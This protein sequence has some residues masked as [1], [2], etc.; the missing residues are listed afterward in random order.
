MQ[1]NRILITGGAGFVGSSLAAAFMKQYPNC[2]VT[3]FD[4]LMRRGSE[5]N[6]EYLKEHGVRFVHG[7]VRCCTDFDALEP[8]DLLIDCSAEPSVS[9][10]LDQG[11]RGLVDINFNGTVN[12]L[13]SARTHDAAVLFVST[14]RVYPIETLRKVY[15][16]EG[17][18]RLIVDEKQDMLGVTER[19]ISER[20][21]IEGPRS[22]Y[23]T[24]K[25]ASEYLLQEY[26]YNFGMRGLINRCGILAGPRQMGRI[27]QGVITFWLANHIFERPLKYMGFGGTGKQV[28]DLL[29]VDDLFDLLVRQ[30]ADADA[31]TG[32]VFNV[33]GGLEHSVSLLELTEL[34]RAITGKEV[35]ITAQPDT[36]SVDIPVYLSDCEKAKAAF[37]WE[38]SRGVEPT[39]EEIARWIEGDLS[40][41]QQILG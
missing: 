41:L 31:W 13:E 4:N 18:T 10:G 8:F 11:A 37:D 22:F 26:V 39:L 24:T 19:G 15:Y 32:E 2:V 14:S 33:G 1:H 25:L 30:L 6:L 7:D 12:C 9:A 40:R 17:A 28:R 21:S 29:H 36:H 23:G 35:V 27:D 5:L 16:T 34:A 3:A 20:F 38:P